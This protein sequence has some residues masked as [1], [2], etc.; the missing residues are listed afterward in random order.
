M[1]LF[2]ALELPDPV[3]EHLASVIA[4]NQLK[5]AMVAKYGQDYRISVTRPENLHVTLKFLGEVDDAAVPALCDA[6]RGVGAEPS[7]EV[8]VGHAELLPPRGPVRVIAAGLDGDVGRIE[9]LHREVEARCQEQ[10]FPAE[11]RT[12]RPHITLQR[13]RDP[14][15]GHLRDR[16]RQPFESHFAG[17]RFGI[18]AF[19]LFESHLRPEGPQYVRLARF[20]LNRGPAS[21]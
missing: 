1:R 5:H 13:C 9:L 6:L 17:P 14:L 7:S 20:P 15:P 12:Y 11:G 10:G 8:W 21:R 19:S 4:Q 16:I 2:L 3:R 18:D